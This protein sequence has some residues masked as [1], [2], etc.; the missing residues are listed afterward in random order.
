MQL[1]QLATA[2]LFAPAIFPIRG[3]VLVVGTAAE[4]CDAHA[5][6]LQ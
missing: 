2:H 3:A 6:A 4:R 5:G 1:G